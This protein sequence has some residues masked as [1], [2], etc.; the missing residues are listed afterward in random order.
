VEEKTSRLVP[1]LS[2]NR[3]EA[4]TDGIFAVAMTLLVLA[5]E[6][7]RLPRNSTDAE[8]VAAIRALAVPVLKYATSFL[9]L[10]TFWVIHIRQA[11]HIRRVDVPYIWLGMGALL[12][13]T[14]VPF[15]TSF[16]ADFPDRS[17]AE[18]FFHFNILGISTFY[19]LQWI[20]ATRNR[21]LVEQDL[22]EETIARS[23]SLGLLIPTFSIMGLM[24]TPAGPFES[25]FI[26]A[27]VPFLAAYL[28]RRQ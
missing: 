2:P 12:L 19:S 15:S 18:Y 27:A 14:L 1:L 28:R 11:Q 13:I 22:P 10:G 16:M 7:P 24:L 21:G 20:H 4:L 25:T 3:V 23:R 9:L 5:L 6:G 8:L 26:Y 17:P